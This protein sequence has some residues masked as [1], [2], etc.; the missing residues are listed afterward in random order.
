ML[1]MKSMLQS[2]I[3]IKT[4]KN[5]LYEGVLTRI[6]EKRNQFHLKEV[7]ICYKDGSYKARAKRR[8]FNAGSIVQIT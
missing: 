3:K 8:W 4:V 5:A 6:N 1:P 7:C 2:A